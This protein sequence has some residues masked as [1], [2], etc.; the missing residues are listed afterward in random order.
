MK[1]KSSQIF[2]LRIF[3]VQN[4]FECNS[5]LMFNAG[6]FVNKLKENAWL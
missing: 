5:W 1:N 6:C 4:T 2:I 3:Q